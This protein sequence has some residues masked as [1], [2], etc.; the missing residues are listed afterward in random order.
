MARSLWVTFCCHG[1]ETKTCLSSAVVVEILSR[2]KASVVCGGAEAK[3]IGRTMAI[4]GLGG[5]VECVNVSDLKRVSVERDEVVEKQS[6]CPMESAGAHEICHDLPGLALV[7]LLGHIRLAHGEVVE[8]SVFCSQSAHV[9]AVKC[10]QTYGGDRES[11]R[12]GPRSKSLP[13]PLPPPRRSPPLR[14]SPR[15]RPPRPRS[16]R[17]GRSGRFERSSRR[18]ESIMSFCSWPSRRRCSAAALDSCVWY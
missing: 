13:R 18:N 12:G 1:W 8:I 15:N 6:D 7:R 11:R 9:L 5:V 14:S 16:G 17:S 2:E 10:W 4:F 3:A